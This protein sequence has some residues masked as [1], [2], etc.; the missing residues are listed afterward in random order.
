[1]ANII[2]AFIA[3][4]AWT[5]KVRSTTCLAAIRE[6]TVSQQQT[7]IR[8]RASDRLIGLWLLAICVMVYLMV[9]L[10]GFTRLTES[11]LSM[12][13]WR[14]VTGWLPPLSDAAWQVHFDGYRASPE[15]LK[16]NHGMSLDEFKGIFWLE[17]LHRLW[18]RVIGLAFALPFAVFLWQRWINKPL[19][20]RLCVLFALGGLQG[21]IGWWMVKSGLVDH[22]D[23][24]QY[25][26]AVHL[27]MAFL[28]LGLGLWIA[29]DQLRTGRETVK[30]T[31]RR[32][33]TVALCLVFIT[34]FSGA[35]V[36]GLNAGLIYNTFPLMLDAFFPAEGF[37]VTPWYL[38][39]FE[40]IP[41]VQFDHRWLAISTFMIVIVTWWLARSEGVVARRRSN[42]L[43]MIAFIQVSLGISTLL[44]MVPVPLAAAHQAGA[45]ALF[46]CAVWLRHGMRCARD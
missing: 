16:I 46:L 8:A 5:N 11:G 31:L 45:V 3:D 1:M 40:D 30:P 7:P 44:L 37:Q 24:S 32:A 39:F 23:V 25:R 20:L 34:A 27:M 43:I 36:A 29:L 22:P 2:I 38:N 6:V 15:Y 41:T 9:V 19:M 21:L 18:G 12:T 14:P 35:L 28:I 4:Q 17:Y 33:S 13:D 42:I 10:G 26:L